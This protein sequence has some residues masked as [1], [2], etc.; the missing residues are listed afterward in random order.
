MN[1]VATNI[2]F[3]FRV[4]GAMKIIWYYSEREKPIFATSV[5]GLSQFLPNLC[6]FEQ[7][8]PLG[9]ERKREGD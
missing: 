3:S 1:S 6:L 2:S 4:M 9:R 8:F 5:E 7:D